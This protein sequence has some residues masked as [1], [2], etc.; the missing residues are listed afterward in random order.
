MAL[1]DLLVYACTYQLLWCKRNKCV[2]LP[3]HCFN[4]DSILQHARKTARLFHVIPRPDAA[5]VKMVG[6]DIAAT[7]VG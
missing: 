1:N 3:A 6:T 5:T 7:K 4:N 2:I